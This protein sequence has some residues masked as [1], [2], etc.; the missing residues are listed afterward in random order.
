MWIG[1]GDLVDVAGDLVRLQEQ[2]VG[3]EV[4]LDL[5]EAQGE[6]GLAEL[7]RIAVSGIMFE[8]AP[9]QTDQARP[10]AAGPRGRRR[11]AWTM[12]KIAL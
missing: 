10:P 9:S 5:G 2:V 1:S 11:R 8:I 7:A 3:E 6:V 4:R 12:S